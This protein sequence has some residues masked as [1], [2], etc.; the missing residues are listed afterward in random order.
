MA[1]SHSLYFMYL[2]HWHYV[3]V[4]SEPLN[5]MNKS[6]GNTA[7]SRPVDTVNIATDG[8]SAGDTS[9]DMSDVQ[10]LMHQ[11]ATEMNIDAQHAIDDLKKDKDLW[12]R[13]ERLKQDTAARHRVT[14]HNADMDVDAG[15]CI[16]HCFVF[17]PE[18]LLET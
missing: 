7:A 15:T 6:R 11:V 10:R 3:N 2:K 16:Y 17:E 5:D 14:E 12:N 18:Q 4:C 8:T 1:P 13:V 9:V